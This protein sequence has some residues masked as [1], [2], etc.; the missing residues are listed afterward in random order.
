MATKRL[1]RLF[2]TDAVLV[3]VTLLFVPASVFPQSKFFQGKTI[4]IIQGRDPGGTGD[5]R[6]KALF[7]FLQKY[8]PGNPTIVS[9]YMPGGGSRKAANHL[10]R[11]ARP[12]GLTIGNLSSAMV[13][14]AVLGESGVLYDIDKFIYLG[15]PYSTY[16]AVFI[17]RKTA[18]LSSI[19]KLQAASGIKVGAQ[20]VGFSTYNEG[21]LFAYLLGLKDP[22]FIAAYGGAEL[23]PALERGEIDGRA[24][25]PDTLLQRNSEWLE[26][27]LVDIHAIMETPEG[28]KHPHPRFRRLP[29][30]ETFARS[31]RERK[32]VQLQRAFRVSG[33]P[34]VLPPGTPKDRVEILQEAFR[35]TY[36]DPEFFREYKKLTAD[37]PTPLLPENHE[38]AIREIPRDAEAIEVFKKLVGAGPLP[39]R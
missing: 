37:D 22:K 34:F 27:N 26:K 13:S 6:V 14:L 9:E 35:K 24:T 28:D 32:V 33:T 38:K 11:T 7:P 16:H 5:L 8:I 25:G 29:E 3:V 23:D 21:R 4:T 36:R 1:A 18:G 19:E 10:F 15:S 2:F 31:D 39:P 12:D 30:I 20:S 17:T